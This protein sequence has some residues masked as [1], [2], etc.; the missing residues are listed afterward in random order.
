MGLAQ[1]GLAV[2]IPARLES[3]RLPR[4]L[5]QTIDSRTVL[6]WTWRRAHVAVGRECVRIATDSDEIA[7]AADAF[8]GQVI[9]TGPHRC[10]SERV[11]AAARALGSAAR[12]VVNLQAD[13]PLLEPQAIRAVAQRLREGEAAIVTC[14]APLANCEAW[15][16][17]AVVKVIAT[18]AGRVLFFSRAPIPWSGATEPFERVRELVSQHVGLYGY[19]RAMLERFVQLPPSPLE[20]AESLEQMR[21]L[22]AG[23]PMALVRLAGAAPAVDT[24]ADLE[25]VRAIVRARGAAA[26]NDGVIQEGVEA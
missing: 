9:R 6:E 13:E 18:R 8:G 25:R 1:E 4:K 3:T 5:L 19:P 26:W 11:A 21:A 2:I 24:P 10:G 12:W 23:M 14:G 20:L 15:S 16:D 22:E 7:A 17:P